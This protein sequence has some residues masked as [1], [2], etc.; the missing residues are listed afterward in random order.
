MEKKRERVFTVTEKLICIPCDGTGQAADGPCEDCG[1][2]GVFSENEAY[3]ENALSE[4]LDG[5]DV[6]NRVWH[7]VEDL[8]SRVARLES[9]IR[10][11]E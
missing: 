2:E 6:F 4:C 3:F 9:V 10:E 11:L 5:D 8:E 1:G 7:I